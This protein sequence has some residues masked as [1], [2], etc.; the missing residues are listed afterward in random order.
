MPQSGVLS[1]FLSFIRDDYVDRS[2]RTRLQKLEEKLDSL[3]FL[4][5]TRTLSV[6]RQ[7]FIELAGDPEFF[8]TALRD[9][10]ILETA[11]HLGRRLKGRGRHKHVGW[12]EAGKYDGLNKSALTEMQQLGLKRNMTQDE[13]RDALLTWYPELTP[14]FVDQDSARLNDLIQKNLARNRSVWD[15][16]VANLGW[17]AAINVA[18]TIS[19]AI[20]MLGSGVPWHIVLAAC[21]AFTTFFTAM[22][23]LNCAMNPDYQI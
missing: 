9:V 17:W 18:G 10:V 23:I 15:C 4:D 3:F 5:E 11:K 1:T 14:D 13:L 20:I 21:I 7:A 19:I 6:D 8:P 12:M 16:C 22:V 2:C